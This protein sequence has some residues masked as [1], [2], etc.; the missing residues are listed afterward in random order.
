[1]DPWLILNLVPAAIIVVVATVATLAFA[2][3]TGR[4]SRKGKR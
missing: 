4:F 2:A 1:M 3:V